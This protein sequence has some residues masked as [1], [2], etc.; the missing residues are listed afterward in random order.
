MPTR[1][2]RSCAARSRCATTIRRRSSS[3]RKALAQLG[4]TDEAIA[5]INDALKI[6]PKRVDFRSSSR[7]RI[8]ARAATTKRS[9]P[10]TK[11]LALPDVPLIVARNAGRFFARRGS[12]SASRADQEGRRAGRA[13][14]RGRARERGRPVPQGRRPDHGQ[15]STT[16]RASPDEGA[17]YRSGAQYLDALG[18]AYES[19]ASTNDT[20]FIE[21]ARFAYERATKADPKLFNPLLGQ[22][23]MLVAQ[24]RLRG[25][26][27]AAARSRRA[28]REQQRVMYWIGRRVLR[29]CATTTPQHAK[30]AAQWLEAA[31]HKGQPELRSSS[32][33][34]PRLASASSTTISTSRPRTPPRARARDAARRGDREADRQRRPTW[35]TETYYTL[36]DKY[37]DVN[38][39]AAQKRAWQRYVDRKPKRRDARSSPS[40]ERTRNVAADATDS[41]VSYAR[42][43]CW[44][45]STSSVAPRSRGLLRQRAAREQGRAAD[46]ARR[47]SRSSS[48]RAPDA[49]SARTS[50]SCSTRP[51]TPT[52]KR[53]SSTASTACAA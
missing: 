19:A 46:A 9:Q 50:R 2:R 40:S 33:P 26:A 52:R 43:P 44:N 3:S 42:R 18:R 45:A 15:A 11:L 16:R 51:R 22:G 24:Q 36:G 25:R 28:R 21:G 47:A 13:D 6:D 17:R 35:L 23:R 48:R 4:R 10:T 39:Q 27:Q 29:R 38:N 20:K 32:A 34:T 31:L 49:S 12:S 8:R 53:S 37:G 30:T 14:P 5:Q 7:A 41:R 1:P